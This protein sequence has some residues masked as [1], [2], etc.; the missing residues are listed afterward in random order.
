MPSELSNEERFNLISQNAEEI[1]SEDE[2]KAAL[3]SGKQLK[4]YIGFEPSGLVH[5]GWKVT[6]D[7]I[8]DLL[9]AGVEL[10]IFMADWHAFINDKYGGDID[11]IRLCGEY[12]KD[13][14]AAL[15]V[16]IS[17]IKFVYASELVDNSSY[18]EKVLRIAKNSSLARVRRSMTI[19]G[20]QE[21]EADADS[22]MFL[23]PSMQAADIFE[24]GV[25]IAYGGMDQRKAHMLARDVAEKLGWQKP[26]ALHTPLLA[27]LTGGGDRMDMVDAKMSKSDPDSCIYLHDTP[28]DIKRKIKKAYCVEGEVE[29]NPIID[30]C[31]YIVLPELSEGMIIKR[32]EK[33]GG[34]MQIMN[35][36]ELV[37]VYETSQL[38]PLDLKNAVTSYLTDML[39]PA[40]EY[41]DKHPEN[42]EVVKK[43]EITR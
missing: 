16:D 21:S 20:R 42:L 13:C 30:L 28:D 24:L 8:N 32:D 29:N 6:A 1:I 25:D 26:I 9:N 36:R 18:W 7:K 19:M 11:N 40:R 23:Y 2:L 43:L 17:K 39:T 34:D 33:Y 3:D 35:Y 31:R 4:S 12:M 15:G 38:H 22:S 5:I 14:F 41:F 37:D 10:T 27:G